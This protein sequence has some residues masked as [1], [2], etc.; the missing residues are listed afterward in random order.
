MTQPD[1]Y[2][3]THD[4]AKQVDPTTIEVGDLIYR[5]YGWQKVIAVADH[6]WFVAVTYDRG[7]D[8]YSRVEWTPCEKNKK[9][10]VRRK[11][12]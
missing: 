1:T 3:E 7:E 4:T 8:H 10:R 12:G 6:D 9:T 5:E 11:R 2:A